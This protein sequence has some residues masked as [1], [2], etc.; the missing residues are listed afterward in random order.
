MGFLTDQ[1]FLEWPKC[2]LVDKSFLPQKVRGA[3]WHSFGHIQEIL[4]SRVIIL[5]MFTT[6]RTVWSL[7]GRR[8]YST[9]LTAPIQFLSPRRFWMG[10]IS[11]P[12][13]IQL[14]NVQSSD[15]QLTWSAPRS[16]RT[17][18]Y[19]D[20]QKGM[21]AA[22]HNIHIFQAALFMPPNFSFK[23]SSNSWG[24]SSAALIFRTSSFSGKCFMRLIIASLIKIVLS[25]RFNLFCNA[26]FTNASVLN[27]SCI[28]LWVSSVMLAANTTTVVFSPLSSFPTMISWN[29]I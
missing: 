1:N 6:N 22:R 24:R 28:R 4:C 21:L 26:N 9:A 15:G 29:V 27:R 13:L 16:F 11:H 14:H 23:K 8:N 17:L 10:K 20:K 5:Q 19:F 7:E 18:F 25:A 3:G 12:F 2:S